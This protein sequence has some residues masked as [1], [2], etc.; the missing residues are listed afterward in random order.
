MIQLTQEIHKNGP[1]KIISQIMEQYAA[2][3]NTDHN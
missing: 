3:K 2:Y 1:H